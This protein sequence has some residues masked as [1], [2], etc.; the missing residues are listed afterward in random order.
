MISLNLQ[1][2]AMIFSFLYGIILAFFFNVNY[3][4]LFSYKKIVQVFCSLIFCV[5][6]FLLYFYLLQ[7]LV[8]G[9]IHIY[10]FL[11]IIG[12][13]FLG[14]VIFKKLFRKAYVKK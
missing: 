7:I 2:K 9:Y 14:F 3:K 4:L 12:G 10:F 6:V 13:F 1:L 8:N 5:D 11:L